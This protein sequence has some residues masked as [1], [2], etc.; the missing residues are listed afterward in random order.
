M[1]RVGNYERLLVEWASSRLGSPFEYGMCDCATL[2]C[3]ALEVML[4]FNPVPDLPTWNSK[5][6]ALKVWKITGGT[7]AQ[8]KK[9]AAK[10]VGINFTQ[11]GDIVVLPRPS[12]HFATAGIIING[13]MLSIAAGNRVSYYSLNMIQKPIISLRLC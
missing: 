12:G 6:E 2:L 9:L 5:K 13:K 10:E 3:E 4:G 8:L 11:T 7:L 1:R